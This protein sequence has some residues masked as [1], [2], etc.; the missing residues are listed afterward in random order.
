M[1]FRAVSQ[2]R[3]PDKDRE[4]WFSLGE[5][6]EMTLGFGLPQLR[7]RCNCFISFSLDLY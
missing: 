1:R 2:L 7:N 6:H 4:E 5:N 3:W